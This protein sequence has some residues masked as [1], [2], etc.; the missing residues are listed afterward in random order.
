MGR[1]DEQLLG[2]AE[3]LCGRVVRVAEAVAKDGA[4]RRIADHT[5]S[6]GTA[7]GA[8]LFEADEALSRAALVECL[9]ISVMELN[10]T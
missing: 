1:L 4:S 7:V 2:W 9:A 8:N 10:E 6:S 3:A 5:L